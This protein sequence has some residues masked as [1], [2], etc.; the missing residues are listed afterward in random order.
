MELEH[1]LDGKHIR[2]PVSACVIL[3][4]LSFRFPVSF[5]FLSFRP[6]FLKLIFW[7]RGDPG[8]PVEVR[9][10]ERCARTCQ[11]EL[12]ASGLLT[13]FGLFQGAFGQLA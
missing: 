6:Q 12:V 2:R 8:R 11:L 5:R 9:P 1:T 10:R 4:C 3:L 7:G 13:A